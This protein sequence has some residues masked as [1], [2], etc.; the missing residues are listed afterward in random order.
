MYLDQ[1][2]FQLKIDA[3]A[4]GEELARALQARTGLTPAIT[5][6]AHGVQPQ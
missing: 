4:N 6:S 5:T 1:L 2:A 3:F